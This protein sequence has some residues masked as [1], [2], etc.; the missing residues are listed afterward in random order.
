MLARKASSAHH[1]D[2]KFELNRNAPAKL[3]DSDM[4]MHASFLLFIREAGATECVCPLGGQAAEEPS[5]RSCL[6]ES[7]SCWQYTLPRSQRDAVS[8]F[9]AAHLKLQASWYPG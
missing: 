1:V 3:R 9:A 2:Y 5:E 8:C 6:P 7:V 4:S